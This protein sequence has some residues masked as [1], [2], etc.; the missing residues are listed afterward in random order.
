MHATF[1]VLHDLLGPL[2]LLFLRESLAL[3]F[4]DL[5]LVVLFEFL[6]ILNLILLLSSCL[7]LF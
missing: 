4:R 2:I 1:D 6:E 7:Q 5:F 3:E